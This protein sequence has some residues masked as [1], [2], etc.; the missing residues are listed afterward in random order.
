MA[1]FLIF[2][3]CRYAKARLPDNTIIVQYYDVGR[4][5]LG[6]GVI[7]FINNVLSESFCRV[8]LK[9]EHPKEKLL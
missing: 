6:P 3:A 2:P 9:K 8:T 7:C 4:L 1:I 5:V